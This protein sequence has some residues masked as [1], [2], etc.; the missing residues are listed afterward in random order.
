MQYQIDT[1]I[2]SLNEFWVQLIHFVP[3]LLAVIVILFFGWL[4]AKLART[5]VKRL[6]L[7]TQFDKAAQKSGLETHAKVS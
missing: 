7:L 4:I 6:L 1:F 5:A 2:N 3:K